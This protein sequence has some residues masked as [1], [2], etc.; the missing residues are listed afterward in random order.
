ML[1]NSDMAPPIGE[2]FHTQRVTAP[3]DGTCHTVHSWLCR[4]GCNWWGTLQ[5]ITWKSAAPNKLNGICYSW[6]CRVGCNWWGTLQ[7]IT[8]KSAAPNE[9]NG[10][11]YSYHWMRSHKSPCL[12]AKYDSILWCI[13]SVYTGSR[14]PFK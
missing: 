1:P 9:L 2:Q 3:G 5:Y 7:Y 12:A 8:W 10:I 11:C 4:V 14:N 13:N 6:L